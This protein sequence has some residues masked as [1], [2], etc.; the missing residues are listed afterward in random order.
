M[1]N[2]MFLPSLLQTNKQMKKKKKRENSC[3]HLPSPFH[4][5]CA[6]CILSPINILIYL[7]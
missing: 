1:T 7:N 3:T 2:Y 6:G 5:P 4:H